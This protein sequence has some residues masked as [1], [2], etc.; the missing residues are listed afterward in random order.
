MV[1][2]ESISDQRLAALYS[3][4]AGKRGPRAMPGRPDIDPAELLPLLPHILLIDVIDGGRDFRYRLV[5]T[6]IERHIGRPV[7][8][9]LISEVLSGDYFAYIRSLHQRATTEAAAVYS[10]NNFNVERS[11]FAL[12]A[13]YKRAYRLMLPLARD[14]SSVDIILCGQVFGPIRDGAPPEL[15]LIDKP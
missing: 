13:D 2:A 12:V 6:E 8:G 5:G 1:F 11:G 7:T 15:L 9:R 4:W 3:Y 10:E 14:G